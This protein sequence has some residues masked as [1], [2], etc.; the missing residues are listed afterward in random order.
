MSFQDAGRVE[1]TPF[2]AKVLAY[3]GRCG[4]VNAGGRGS[5]KT[6]ALL[7]DVLDHLRDPSSRV[8]V[9]RESWGGLA[10]LM[11]ELH[12]LSAAAFGTGVT[13]NMQRGEMRLPHGGYVAFSNVSDEASYAKWQGRSFTMLAADE[14]GNYTPAGY[15]FWRR[16]LSNLRAAPGRETR[17]HCTANPAGRSHARILREF[18]RGHEPWVPW[19]DRDGLLWVVTTSTYQEN[20]HIDGKEYERRLAASTGGDRELARAW[21]DGSWDVL[22]GS[23]F[24]P[25][26][27]DRVHVLA[28]V[29]PAIRGCYRLVVGADWGTASPSAA[30]LVGLL[31]EPLGAFR[32]G[33]LFVLDETD[34]CVSDDDLSTGTGV[35]VDQ[36][37]AQL[38]E[39]CKRNGLERV[40]RTISD[41]ARGLGSETVVTELQRCGIPAMRPHVKDRVGTWVLLRSLLHAAVA[42]DGRPALWISERCARLLETLPEAPRSPH[43]AGDVDARWSCDHHLDALAYAVYAL[44][45]TP[46]ATSG[47]TVGAY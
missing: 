23:M 18:V 46:A 33:D 20:P 38:K 17:I 14:L 5:G 42:G 40:P 36:W 27:D 21:L 6:G 12:E 45:G 47:R 35:S 2:Q 41:D 28:R 16:A 29:P 34:T 13:R 8:L 11:D 32:V 3:R 44:Y 24:A 15:A 39:M 25:P 30:L 26:F 1:P 43:R 7:L 9:L 22:G 4:I 10:E 37:A 19:R 31:R